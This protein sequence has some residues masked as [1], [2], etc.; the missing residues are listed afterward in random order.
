M[1]RRRGQRLVQSR[2]VP[3]W[4]FLLTSLKHSD[5]VTDSAACLD[6]QCSKIVQ[7]ESP[8]DR[9]LCMGS[10]LPR[11]SPFP[12]QVD[13]HHC[14]PNLYSDLEVQMQSRSSSSS[15]R[16]RRLLHPYSVCFIPY[17]AN[18]TKERYVRYIIVLALLRLSD[19]VTPRSMPECP[20]IQSPGHP[21][22]R[23]YAKHHLF[24]E[25]HHASDVVWTVLFTKVQEFLSF[26]CSQDFA[27]EAVHRSSLRDGVFF[28]M[29]R[30]F[31]FSL[32][33][34]MSPVFVILGY[35]GQPNSNSEPTLHKIASIE[36]Q[37]Q[38]WSRQMPTVFRCPH[39][40]TR[41]F[42]RFCREVPCRAF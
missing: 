27:W 21:R 18:R 35:D 19:T 17:N 28:G 9:V 22:L 6:R 15:T 32:T 23:H 29:L 5:I 42:A 31:V 38:A 12:L 26:G 4:T 14:F 39:P 10:T 34:M 1:H 36:D 24:L 33:S 13:Q 8:A 20:T 2:S 30:L 37:A 11:L 3:Y 7:G 16:T 40:A 41:H 25:G